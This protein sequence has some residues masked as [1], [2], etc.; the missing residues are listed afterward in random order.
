MKPGPIKRVPTEAQLAALAKGRAI[1]TAGPFSENQIAAARKN[2]KLAIAAAAAMRAVR[3][4]CENGHALNPRAF[5]SYRPQRCEVCRG[6]QR[7]QLDASG[8]LAEDIIRRVLDAAMKAKPSI[9][10][11]ATKATT[12]S[13][14]AL[15]SARGLKAS[16][17]KT[18]R[19]ERNSARY[20]IKIV[21]PELRY[22]PAFLSRP[23]QLCEMPARM[24]SR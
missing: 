23:R 6:V 11:M 3:T 7:K 10:L 13:A 2:I 22:G 19:S 21:K 5:K 1:A 14:V 16:C 17:E 24:L 18:Q 9:R 15:L 8:I 20:L 12:T 4:H